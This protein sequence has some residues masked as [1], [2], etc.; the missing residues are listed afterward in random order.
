MNT[1]IKKRQ[2]VS[3]FRLPTTKGFWLP[4]LGTIVEYYDY[5]LYGFTAALIS[6]LYF[7]ADDSSGSLL[8]TYI[9]FALGSFAKP[10]GSL[11]FGWIGDRFG[12]KIALKWTMLGIV[13]P[14][15]L[16]GIL[17]T[18]QDWGVTATVILIGCRLFQGIFLSGE[19][20]G[21]RI[22]LYETF[23][24]DRPTLINCLVGLASY[25]GV[26][27]ASYAV[28]LTPQLAT[29][30][31]WRIPFLIG[32]VLGIIVFIMRHFLIESADYLIYQTQPLKERQSQVFSKKAFMGTILLCGGVGGL[33]QIFFVYLGSFL[34]NVLPLF[35]STQM[36][37][38][39]PQLLLVHMGAQVAAAWLADHWCPKKVILLGLA[40]TTPL[41]LALGVQLFYHQVN[42]WLWLLLTTSLA[43]VF[44]PGFTLILSR[45]GV[46]ARYRFVSLGHSLGSVLFSGC[47]PAIS[48]F[49][50][51]QTG[52]SFA[53]MVH[54][55]VLC[56]CIRIGVKLLE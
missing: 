48:L 37:K 1:I 35:P 8:K 26:F 50:W 15:I 55:L 7:P 56:A 19:T 29:A 25:F 14:T 42:L 21:I 31:A 39:T 9:V 11:I 38:F 41:I 5:T 53:P 45:S 43:L 40:I 13:I 3:Y 24:K 34:S 6:Q 10:I 46:G 28:S 36:Q 33:N 4:L 44:I 54:A 32:G 52:A 30:N 17:P 20:D 18:Y 2:F 12:R 27:L 51:Q 16:I 23:L 22:M 49:L 47:A